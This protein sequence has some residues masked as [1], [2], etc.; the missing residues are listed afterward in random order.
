MMM[1]R[2]RFVPNWLFPVLF[3]AALQGCIMD[4]LSECRSVDNLTVTFRVEADASDGADVVRRLN[5]VDVLL[6]DASGCLVEHKRVERADLAIYPGVHFTVAPG[7][8]R[9]L[10]WANSASGS[11][12]SPLVPGESLIEQGYIEMTG[13]GDTL[14]YAPAKV[15]PDK[16]AAS[17]RAD[18]TTS[19]DPLYR[20]IVPQGSGTVVKEIAFTR[21]Y[22]SVSL[23]LKGLENLSG[24][25]E[26]Q[27]GIEAEAYNLSTRYDLLFN[28][29]SERRDDR[30]AFTGS[31]T[32]DGTLPA[33]RF[34]SAYGPV[35]NDVTFNLQHLPGD[36]GPVMILLG[37][38]LTENP[39]PSFDDIDILVEFF[40]ETTGH[41]QV[42]IT[43]PDW[44]SRPVDPVY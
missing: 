36:V 12:L 41:V 8:Y 13:A 35:T 37:Q 22:R 43:M 17:L 16:G 27:G 44:S 18:E 39:P 10:A 31:L 20:T 3:M 30:R 19:D 5:S 23:Y 7:E 38:Y 32:P 2:L 26:T 29:L 24:G 4:N 21:A 9:V 33:A 11:R 14:Y 28:T 25:V 1:S 6:F 15:H 40:K 34:L 42:S